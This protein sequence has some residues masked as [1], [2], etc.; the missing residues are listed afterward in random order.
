MTLDGPRVRAVAVQAARAAGE[1]LR[2][3]IDSIR[4]VRHK[5][6]VDLVTDVD[7]ASEQEVVGRLRAEP[8]GDAR[9]IRVVE[10]ELD[11]QVF[12][13]GGMIESSLEKQLREGWET[14]AVA[15]NAFL[16]N[17]DAFL[18]GAP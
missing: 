13:I 3:R 11:A 18:V 8:D 12:G 15:T 6:A 1:I 7:L 2:D 16:A 14:S 17:P 5:S 4:E 10:F 9:V